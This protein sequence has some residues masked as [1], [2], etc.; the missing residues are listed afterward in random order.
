MPGAGERPAPATSGAS[1]AGSTTAT[2][3]VPIERAGARA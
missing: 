1:K 3:S 2:G